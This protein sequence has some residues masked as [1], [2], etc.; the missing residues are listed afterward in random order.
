[1][2]IAHLP[3]G[4]FD[5]NLS[6]TL[7]TRIMTDSD[8][9]GNLTGPAM[10]DF[11]AAL[12]TGSMTLFLLISKSWQLT[13]I[14][15]CV[16]GSGATILYRAFSHVRPLMR[17]QSKIRAEVSGGLTESIGG[18]RVV[19]SY[20]AEKREGAV[21]AK[22][23][24]RLF[25]N[26]MRI[27]P[28][29]STIQSTG[30]L[31]TGLSTLVVVLFGGRWLLESRWTV[32]DYVQYAA[33]I[34]YIVNPVFMLVNVG[35]LF[36]QAVADLNRIGEVF[37]ERV[38]DKDHARA[39]AVPPIEGDVRFDDVG[40]G[41]ELA[42][43]VLHNVSFHAAPGTVTALVG[44]SGSGKSTIISLLCAFHQPQAGQIL[45]DNIDLASVTL[46]SYRTQLGLVLQ[47]TFL[48]DGTMRENLVF[49]RPD[50]L[51]EE[52]LEACRMACVDEFAD[53]LPKRYETVVGERGV[54]L[55]GGQKQRVSIARAILANPRIL[56]L[57]EATSSLD[58]ESEAMIQ[59]GVSHLLQGRTT[60]V[61][62]HRLPTIRHADQILVLDEGRILEHG[63]R[64][65]LMNTRD[66]TSISIPSNMA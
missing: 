12:L 63:T 6:S 17:D 36:T 16:L 61:I 53:K 25:D 7:V 13:L 32:G 59:E 65:S 30:I 52:L 50:A 29:T 2:H 31:L 58:S 47:E 9:M 57:D 20:R 28:G 44:P 11:C 35:T 24:Q 5:S 39:V 15:L 37:A 22:G 10:L 64:R 45:L 43:R 23:V 3:I 19:K 40:F 41:Y 56:I 4:Y 21:Y 8:G 55:S 33:L 27:R 46:D 54:K 49:A 66:A 60:F 42:R 48:F 38:E 1:L 34:T 18:I 51:Q 14:L 62:A 26:F